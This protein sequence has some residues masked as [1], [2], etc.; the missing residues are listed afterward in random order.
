MVWNCN[1][2]DRIVL[3]ICCTKDLCGD[4]IE[5]ETSVRA[6]RDVSSAA[7]GKTYILL[8]AHDAVVR[9]KSELKLKATQ[10]SHAN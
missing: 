1:A 5:K 6:P 8:S 9:Y 3:V 2:Q 10:R 7:P 4:T